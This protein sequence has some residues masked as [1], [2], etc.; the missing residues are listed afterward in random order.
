MFYSNVDAG[1]DAV[2]QR[3]GGG[4][5]D[6]DFFFNACTLREKKKLSQFPKHEIGYPC[7]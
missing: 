2:M 1:R 3:G 5:G 6:S 4:G 7:T